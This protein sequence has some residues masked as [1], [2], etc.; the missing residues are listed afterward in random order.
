MNNDFAT[1]FSEFLESENKKYV[2]FISRRQYAIE[3]DK[4]YAHEYMT[5]DLVKQTRP[6]EK[7]DDFGNPID[8]NNAFYNDTIVLLGYREPFYMQIEFPRRD[9]ITKEQFECLKRIISDVEKHRANHKDD[10]EFKVF[11]FGN[12]NF[13]LEAKDYT[14]NLAELIDNCEKEIVDNDYLLDEVIIGKEIKAKTQL[15]E[16]EIDEMVKQMEENK[17]DENGN[18]VLGEYE[19]LK[20]MGFS[21]SSMLMLFTLF[22][23]ITLLI[24]GIFI[25]I[26]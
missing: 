21:S 11:A 20:L 25:L 17:I 10:S 8:P 3:I 1:P 22:S 7:I 15:T 18:I 26:Y 4:S 24:L 12:N 14:D 9:K 5:K 6:D 23:S 13:N 16:A 19:D 2:I